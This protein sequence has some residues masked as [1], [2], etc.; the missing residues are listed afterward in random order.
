VEELGVGERTGAFA[1]MPGGSLGALPFCSAPRL[2]APHPEEALA[3][4][5]TQPA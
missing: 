1:E 4:E 2:L 3:G 5:C